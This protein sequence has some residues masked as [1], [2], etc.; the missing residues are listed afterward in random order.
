MASEH[1]SIAAKKRWS[2]TKAWS[3]LAVCCCGCDTPL[4]VSKTPDRQKFFCQG[5][6]ARLKAKLRAVLRRE[7]KREELPAAARVNL[8][9]IGFIQSNP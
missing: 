2:D 6:D 3:L 9:K 4:A 8:S 7:M 5:H 1:K